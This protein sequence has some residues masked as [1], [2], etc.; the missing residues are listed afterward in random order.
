MTP[1]NIIHFG[2]VDNPLP[3]WREADLMSEDW[4]N[5]EDFPIEQDVKAII[6]FD[7]DKI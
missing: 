3:D 6:G 1:D 4:D 7:P 2:S 5:D